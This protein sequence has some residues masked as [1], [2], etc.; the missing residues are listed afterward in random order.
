LNEAP[1]RS[2]RV[3]N[4]SGRL[5][6]VIVG[7]LYGVEL[8]DEQVTVVYMNRYEDNEEITRREHWKYLVK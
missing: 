7:S 8:E 2:L 3:A 5:V 4:L 6:N 1:L